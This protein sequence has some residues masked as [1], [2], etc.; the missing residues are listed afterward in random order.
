MATRTE[1]PRPEGGKEDD[2]NEKVP[3]TTS[4]EGFDVSLSQTPSTS[5]L[6]SNVKFH[7]YDFFEELPNGFLGRFDVVHVR[8]IALVIKNN[9]PSSII[10]NLTKMYILGLDEFADQVAAEGKDPEMEKRIRNMAR[11]AGREV[12]E[13]GAIEYDKKVVLA[14]KGLS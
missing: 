11:K 13:G 9:D 14:R 1:V 8:L 7:E 10:R 4:L 2:L 12:R 6:P 3:S 5:W